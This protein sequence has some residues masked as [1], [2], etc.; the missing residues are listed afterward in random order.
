[1]LRNLSKETCSVYR[2]NILLFLLVFKVVPYVDAP[3]P[4]GGVEAAEK[5]F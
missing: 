1:M 5:T 2:L 3:S 4:P